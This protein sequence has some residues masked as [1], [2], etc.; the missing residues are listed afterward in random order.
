MIN[1]VL[2]KKKLIKKLIFKKIKIN[3]NILSVNIVG[4]F[5]T[6]NKINFISDIDVVVIVNKLNEKI[7]KSINFNVKNI[8]TS[9]IGLKDYKIK[10]NNTFGPLKYN[11]S[12]NDI[13]IHLMI[14]DKISH[15][16]HVIKSP[17]TCYD[18][19]R[20]SICRGKTLK[21]IFPVGRIQLRDFLETRRSLNNYIKDLKKN[22]IT[23]YNYSFYKNT[24]KFNKKRKVLSKSHL[25]EYIFHIQKNLV[26]N[27]YKY[28]FD[29][30]ISLDDNYIYYLR[31]IFGNNLYLK[32][33]SHFKLFYKYKKKKTLPS[34]FV[35]KETIK[36]FNFLSNFNKIIHNSINK[37]NKVVF[38]RH[39]R[40]SLNN[41][42]FLGIGRNPSIFLTNEKIIFDENNYKFNSFYSSSLRRS[43]ETA[44][45]IFKQKKV[46]VCKELDEINYGL[47]EGLNFN[48]FK[49]LY[50]K[51]FKLMHK[52]YDPKFPLGESYKDVLIRLNTFIEKKLKNNLKNNKKKVIGVVTHNVTLR[53]LIGSHYKIDRSD[54][55]KIY[56]P[57]LCPLEFIFF[58]NKIRPNIPRNI[59]KII[60]SKF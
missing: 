7:F 18:W 55:Y 26:N 24:Y 8:E 43:I 28:L 46:V 37:S 14:Y 45:L 49:N 12:T 33:I 2:L 60:F 50:P 9:K 20:S 31:K 36:L 29:K 48:E 52:G 1:Q 39:S 4:S 34:F 13:I 32:F 38:Y 30:N 15:K 35:K 53:C 10:I 54:W 25:A 42:R 59:Y 3:R 17:F 23:Y 58:K 19:E 27:Y 6:N 22:I 11:L 56:I 44:K 21:D 16:D 47:A 5:I 51:I 41:D 57:H 40:T